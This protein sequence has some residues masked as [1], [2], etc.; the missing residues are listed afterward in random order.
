M[1]PKTLKNFTCFI[2]GVGF[3]G[4]IE[5]GALPKLALMVE[6]YQ[7]GGMAGPVDIDMGSVEKMEFELTFSEYNPGLMGL[8]GRDDLQ[9]SLRGAQGND[10][11]AVIV[12]TRGLFRELDGGSWKAGEKGSL[13]C[14]FTAKYLKMTVAS[15]ELIEVDI[16]GLIFK[17]GGVDRNASMRTALGL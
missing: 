3:A 2:D 8:F 16:E 4:L 11:E 17:T 15:D 13:K 12:E 5:E 7:G 1:I 6:E 9:V 10:N 14:A